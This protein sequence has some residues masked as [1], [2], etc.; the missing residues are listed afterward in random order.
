M[1]R[2]VNGEQTV[3]V[4][5]ALVV[6]TPLPWVCRHVGPGDDG[7]HVYLGLGRALL[8]S[9]HLTLKK[10]DQ[11]IF[12]KSQTIKKTKCSTNYSPN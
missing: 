4:S 6:L 9:P 2:R 5:E 3:R 10:I 8:S 11:T 1:S 12:E 7:A